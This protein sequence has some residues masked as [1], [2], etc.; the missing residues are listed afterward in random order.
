MVEK[1]IGMIKNFKGLMLLSLYFLASSI[2][3][4]LLM[5]NFFIPTYILLKLVIALAMI[6]LFIFSAGE[7]F[8]YIKNNGY[9]LKNF[10]PLLIIFFTIFIIF[11]VPFKDISIKHRFKTDLNKRE[12]I[13]KL[14]IAGDSEKYSG[15]V[16]LPK[17]YRHLSSSEVVEVERSDKAITILFFV[18]RGLDDYTGYL[19]TSDEGDLPDGYIDCSNCESEKLTE[20]WYWVSHYEGY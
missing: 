12:E 5:W 9:C 1:T 18:Y 8:I 3:L 15:I 17:N 10:L 20:N 16:D 14:I 2:I 11:L 6:M 4:S 19:Y 7:N 13:V